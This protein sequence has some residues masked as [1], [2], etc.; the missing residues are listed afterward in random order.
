MELTVAEI[1]AAI[2]A[3]YSHSTLAWGDKTGLCPVGEIL[4]LRGTKFSSNGFGV[5]SP[6]DNSH[7]AYSFYKEFT[8][9]IAGSSNEYREMS[10]DDLNR[11]LLDLLTPESKINDTNDKGPLTKEEAKKLLD[12]Q[13][14]DRSKDK[15]ESIYQDIRYAIS[16]RQSQIT[17][18]I[19]EGDYWTVNTL[20]DMGHKLTSLHRSYTSVEDGITRYHYY[21]L[22]FV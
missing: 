10:R 22:S 16:K 2:H 11:K 12:K 15:L 21:N 1:L 20:T 19:E 8:S 7:N 13:W 5:Q 4:K 17:I 6:M 3:K 14:E 18:S 9:F